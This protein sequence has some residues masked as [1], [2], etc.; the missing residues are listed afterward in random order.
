MKIK[1][2]AVNQDTGAE[3]FEGECDLADALE[4]ETEEYG[5]ALDELRHQGRCWIGGGAAQLFL[6]TRAQK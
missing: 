4:P 1:T 5:E 2:Y 3:T 6:L